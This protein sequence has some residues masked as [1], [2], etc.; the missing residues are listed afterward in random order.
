[1]GSSVVTVA[2]PVQ[3]GERYLPEVLDAVLGQAVDRPVELLVV[4]SGSTDRSVEIARSRGA[5]VVEIPSAEF[6]HGGTRNMMMELAGGDHVVFLSQDA[7]P[8]SDRWLSN[9]LE[10]FELAENV[11]LA[12]GPYEARLGAPATVARELRDYFRSFAR[13]GKPT[14]QSWEAA[15]LEPRLPGAQTFFTDANGCVLRRAWEVVPYRDVPYAE[16]HLLACEM[17]EAGYSKVFHPG[18]VVYHSHEYSALALLRRCFDEW[19]GL[20]EVYGYREPIRPRRHLHRV[21]REVTLDRAFMREGGL[22]GAA[23]T[24]GTLRSLGHH[25]VR[26]V[27]SVLGGRAD[28]LPARVRASLSLEGRST[29]VP[30]PPTR[31]LPAVKRRVGG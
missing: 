1:M 25:V 30:A 27:G 29:F 24:R 17:L 22:S 8:A 6:S 9:L 3:N 5:R 14:V 18:A 16:D 12:F 26:A 15:S 2:V 11:A 4:D 19:R 21:R 31:G 28:R 7:T 20:A 13:D 10:G 23:L